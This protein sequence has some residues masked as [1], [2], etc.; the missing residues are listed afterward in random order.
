MATTEDGVTSR[1]PGETKPEEEINVEAE[2]DALK[3]EAVET[4][5][6]RTIE[7]AESRFRT[8]VCVNGDNKSNSSEIPLV[9]GKKVKIFGSTSHEHC[10]TNHRIAANGRGC[11][12]G[13]FWRPADHLFNSAFDYLLSRSHYTGPGYQ[14]G[15]EA[16]K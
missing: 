11:R 12:R 14:E 3:P 16:D 10:N 4:P 8:H 13:L 7:V 9:L 1:D 15:I 5:A 2:I 6:T